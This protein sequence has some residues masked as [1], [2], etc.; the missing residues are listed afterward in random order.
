MTGEITLRGRVLAIG[1]VKE[2]LLAAY[3]AGITEVLIPAENAKDLEE[4]PSEVR[5]ALNVRP[6]DTMEEVLETALEEW[7][8]PL[9]P[10]LSTFLI[11]RPGVGGGT[12]P[13]TFRPV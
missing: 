13:S 11:G 8:V 12:Q 3:I 10:P 9:A 4:I 2:K 5:E 6:V 1:G 7:T